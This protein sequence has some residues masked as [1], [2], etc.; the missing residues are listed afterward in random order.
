[1]IYNQSSRTARSD[2]DVVAL[3]Y[4]I[5]KLPSQSQKVR[6]ETAGDC[7]SL[8]GSVSG[9][10]QAHQRTLT[11]DNQTYGSSSHFNRASDRVTAIYSILDTPNY[12]H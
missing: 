1:M 11:G 10:S 6:G 8:Q 4:A 7:R 2:V 3:H 9:V 5:G 12:Q